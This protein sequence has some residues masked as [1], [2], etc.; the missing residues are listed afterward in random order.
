MSAAPFGSALILTIS[1]AYVRMM[2][3]QDY[4]ATE[5][6]ILNANYVARRLPTYPDP[7]LRPGRDG[8]A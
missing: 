5:V 3:A 2:G 8:G 6:A 1:Y 4:R 7:L